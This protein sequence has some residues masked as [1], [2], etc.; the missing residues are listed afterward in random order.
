[1]SGKTLKQKFLSTEQYVDAYAESVKGRQKRET[2]KYEK[3]LKA[4]LKKTDYYIGYQY[5]CAN[6][7]EAKNI[8]TRV[9]YFVKKNA[10]P[11]RVS[12]SGNNVFVI[13]AEGNSKNA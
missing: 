3:E 11:V 4:F 5:E 8:Y 1:M 9:R 10:S 13:R 7:A 2:S 6:K 12:I